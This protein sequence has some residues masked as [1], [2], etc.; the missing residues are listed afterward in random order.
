MY[1]GDIG[2]PSASYSSLGID[3]LSFFMM[4]TMGTAQLDGLGRMT[5]SLASYLSRNCCSDTC[6]HL[7]SAPK[8][9]SLSGWDA[10]KMGNSRQNLG[11][12]NS[13]LAEGL[14][15][16]AVYVKEERE[17][18]QMQQGRE[19]GHGGWVPGRVWF[20]ILY[21]WLRLASQKVTLR[22]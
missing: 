11:F 7:L 19:D 9:L 8:S 17:C 13:H 5:E 2:E 3:F 1:E 10:S 22:Q 6:E 16:G 21:R 15:L 20:R 14:E 4:G 18:G 12:C